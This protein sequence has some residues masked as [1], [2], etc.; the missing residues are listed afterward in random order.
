[1]LKVTL[2]SICYGLNPFRPV[3]VWRL[4]KR[5][6]AVGC[7]RLT[8]STFER[9][10][11]G[12]TDRTEYS[13]WTLNGILT[14]LPLQYID[15]EARVSTMFY[16]FQYFAL[17]CLVA[18]F[19]LHIWLDRS[20]FE[21]CQKFYTTGFLGQEFY[22]VKTWK[23]QLFLLVIK[24]RKFQWKIIWVLFLWKLKWKSKILII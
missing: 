13:V 9:E 6:F 4:S 22:T 2:F 7:L 15:L 11:G 18:I 16:R 1:M 24:Q 5:S 17:F 14:T 10:K 3:T 12:R 20:R 21:I 8:S 19:S 23:L